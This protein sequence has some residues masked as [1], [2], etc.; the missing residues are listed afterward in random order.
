MD[1]ATYAATS[2][3]PSGRRTTRMAKSLAKASS[4][5][6]LVS[7]L[8]TAVMESAHWEVRQEDEP[9]MPSDD[10]NQSSIKQLKA[11]LRRN[12]LNCKDMLMYDIFILMGG[13]SIGPLR[14]MHP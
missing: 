6:A 9:G 14:A 13:S 3:N 7:I 1:A 5:G 2:Q 4:S 10:K 11:D 12:F 8:I